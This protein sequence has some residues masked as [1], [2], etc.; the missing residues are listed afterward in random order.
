M[1]ESITA[2]DGIALAVV[3]ISGIMGFARGFLRELATL[4]AFIG[5]L[6]AAYYARVFFHDDLSALLP[7]NLAPWTADVI[8]LIVAFIIVYVLIAWIGQRLSK[9]IHGAEGIGMFDHVAGAVFG[10]LRGFVALVFFVVLLGLVLEQSRI[11]SFIQN[12]ISYPPLRNMAD[13][14]NVE[15]AKVG[16][17][18]QAPLSSEEENGQ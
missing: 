5:A 6:A 14:V 16:K 17:E 1:L 4:G 10:V 12:G 2:F 8:L 15:A 18:V 7:P 11:P 9:N 13:F 3:V